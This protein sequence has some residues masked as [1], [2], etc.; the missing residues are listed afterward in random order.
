MSIV[1]R[2]VLEEIKELRRSAVATDSYST[3]YHRAI[4]GLERAIGVL[5]QLDMI[6][7]NVTIKVESK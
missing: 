2:A 3:G 1:N 6:T 5:E 7:A 4:R